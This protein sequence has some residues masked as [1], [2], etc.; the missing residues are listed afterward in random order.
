MKS[1]PIINLSNIF[2]EYR[3]EEV[4]TPVLKGVSLK[5]YPKDF[6][7]ITGP[8]GSGKSTLMNIIGV[9]DVA[10]SGSYIING[11]N[12]VNLSEDELAQIRNKEIGFV[13]QS[14]NLL[15]RTSALENVMLPAIYSG[16]K[17]E[18]FFPA[19]VPLTERDCIRSVFFAI[20]VSIGGFGFGRKTNINPTIIIIPIIVRILFFS[21][22]EFV[23][24]AFYPLL[25]ILFSQI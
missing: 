22:S 9:L 7:A 17:E 12:I 14:F 6:V 1:Q 20:A 19:I 25:A 10:T 4:V 13:F 21:N 18:E 15:N 2:K 8:S 24:N 11:T 5:V 3:T 16:M 23:H